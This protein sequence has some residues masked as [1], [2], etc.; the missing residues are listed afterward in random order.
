MKVVHIGGVTTSRQELPSTDGFATLSSLGSVCSPPLYRYVDRKYA[1]DFLDNGSILLRPFEHYQQ[2][3]RAG[4]N[5]ADTS[6]GLSSRVVVSG[7]DRERLLRDIQGIVNFNITES[8]VVTVDGCALERRCHPALVLCH[9]LRASKRLCRR[10]KAGDKSPRAV[11]FHIQDPRRY[12]ERL[13]RFTRT[14]PPPVLTMVS[15]I[16][17]S[18]EPING[19][20]PVFVKRSR[21]AVERELRVVFFAKQDVIDMFPRPI[22]LGSLRDIVRVVDDRELKQMSDIEI[23][24]L[25]GS[26]S[27]TQAR[28]RFTH[29]PSQ[30]DSFE[31]LYDRESDPPSLDMHADSLSLGSHI[32]FWEQ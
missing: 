1:D 8:D 11:C 12:F 29:E 27:S 6:E 5:R 17:Y 22:Q 24:H 31:V 28:S 32:L 3:E 30:R 7:A 9:S 20:S 25:F 14:L 21:F 18:D 10:F 19:L 13:E 16:V 2:H 4:R 23:D 15:P 26:A